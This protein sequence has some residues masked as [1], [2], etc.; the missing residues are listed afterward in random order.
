MK[1]TYMKPS[2]EVMKLKVQH[3]L[4]A[5]SPN[6]KFDPTSKTSTMDSRRGRNDWDDE[7]D[8]Y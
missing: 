1:Q 6:A 5:G 7:E 2:T 8:G 4:L 3:H